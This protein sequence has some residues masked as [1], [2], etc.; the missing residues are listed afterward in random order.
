MISNILYFLRI[1]LGSL[2]LMWFV[3]INRKTNTKRAIRYKQYRMPLIA[4]IYCIACFAFLN[5]INNLLTNLLLRVV[6]LLTLFRVPTEYVNIVR[7]FVSRHMNLILLFTSNIVILE[8]YINVK[9]IALAFFKS[10]DIEEDSIMGKIISIFYEYD[11]NDDRWYIMRHFSQARTFLKVVY[12]GGIIISFMALNISGVLVKENLIKAPFYP[13]FPVIIVGELAFFIEGLRKDEL[14]S[15]VSL[16]REVSSRTGDYDLLRKPLH[17]LFGDKLLSDGMTYNVESVSGS[18][19][20]DLLTEIEKDGGHVGENY[21]KYIRMRIANGLMP[22]NDYV[23]SGF[24]L[25]SG[26][27]LLFNTPFYDSLTPY[28]FY[29][30]NRALLQGGKVLIILGMHGTADDLAQWCARGMRE[31]TRIPNEWKIELLGEKPREGE[32]LPDIGIISRSGVHNLEMHRANL[33]FLKNVTFLF[34]VEPSKLVTTAQIGLTLLVKNCGKTRPMTFCSVDRNCDGLVDSLSHILMTNITEVSATEYPHGKS[35]YMYWAADKDYLQHRIVQGVS[36]YLGLGT[37]LSMVALKNQVQRSTWYGGE[38]YPVLDA[39]WIAK[40]YYFDLMSYA[41]LPAT[42]EAFDRYFRTSFNMCNEGASDYSFVVVEDD[43]NNLFETRRVFATI[44]KRQGFVNVISPEYLLRDYM[45]N[46]SEIFN[47]D[48]KAIPY[49]T[50]DYART[51]RNNVLTLFL[52]LYI[53]GINEADLKKELLLIGL[54]NRTPEK[55]LWNEICTLFGKTIN[56]ER[57]ENEDPIISVY[58]A[59]ECREYVFTRQDTISFSRKY[60]VSKG[61]FESIYAI[62]NKDFVRHIL[63]DLQNAEYVAEHEGKA[64]YIGTELKGHIFQKYLPGQFFTLNGKYYEMVSVTP[65]NRIMI[66][67]ASEHINGRYFYRQVRNYIMESLSDSDEL[68]EVKSVNGIDVS[69]QF[70]NFTAQTTAYWK[71]K[72]FND[73]AHGDLVKIEGVP[74]RKYFKKRVLKLD[75]SKR[76]E[77]FTDGVQRALT[78]LLNEVF[79]TLFAENRSFISAVTPGESEAPLTYSMEF[80]EGCEK[81]EKAIYII[82]DSQLDIGLLVTVER[83]I[84]RI[85][86]I[87]A[88]YLAW[89]EEMREESAAPP[90]AKQ[91]EAK[92]SSMEEA[93]ERLEENENQ[94]KKKKSL[95]GRFIDWIRSLFGKKDKKAKKDSETKEEKGKAPETPVA[96]SRLEETEDLTDND[97]FEEEDIVPEDEFDSYDE[98]SEE[99]EAEREYEENT[100]PEQVLPESLEEAVEEFENIPEMTQEEQELPEDSEEIPA[101][102]ENN[103]E[104]ENDNDEG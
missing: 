57:D 44:A 83:N 59:E 4:L 13:V 19:I 21:A 70:A 71:M 88:D 20:E 49:I 43:R 72:A 12:Y 1:A 53:E 30:M 68:G 50:A 102:E 54:D 78:N 55:T 77:E 33:D 104:G 94:E 17:K 36:R 60:S 97:E 89:D 7:D 81:C 23:R 35:S 93:L 15:S 25:A 52:K 11:R 79:V 95:F 16:N 32:E 63:K 73:F 46:N 47:A 40:Q 5:Q 10:K 100:E 27:S 103:D 45:S 39:H 84:Q 37:E 2:P 22:D 64:D 99:K 91:S 90:E 62:E 29:A 6:T 42:Q 82:E 67:R 3:N 51:K 98:A 28:V 34:I 58:D 75:F 56:A 87:I 80:T 92:V 74:D 26:K 69:Y 9:R 101:D 14:K 66:R 86:N 96:E 18:T 41:E 76:G 48:P 8:T 65:D 85:L 38:V 31:A 61:V 24:E